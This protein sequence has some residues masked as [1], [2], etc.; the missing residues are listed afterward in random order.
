MK[1][2]VMKEIYELKV[3]FYVKNHLLLIKFGGVF[4]LL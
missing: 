3:Y 2:K 4:E 1:S